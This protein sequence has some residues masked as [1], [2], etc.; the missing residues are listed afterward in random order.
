MFSYTRFAIATLRLIFC[1]LTRHLFPLASLSPFGTVFT[2]TLSFNWVRRGFLRSWVFP[3]E[4][5]LFSSAPFF[6]LHFSG[7]P[8]YLLGGGYLLG[9]LTCSRSHC[10]VSS[11]PLFFF[12]KSFSGRSGFAHASFWGGV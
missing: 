8:F 4:T 3:L 10:G 12:P 11:R 5:L 7:G 2:L 6:G 1:P 9:G